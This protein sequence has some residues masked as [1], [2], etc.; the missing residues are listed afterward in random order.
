MLRVFGIRYSVF[1]NRYSVF[2]IQYSVKCKLQLFPS[3]STFD[4]Q[5]SIFATR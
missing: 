5:Y 4:L 3:T 2:S 1:S